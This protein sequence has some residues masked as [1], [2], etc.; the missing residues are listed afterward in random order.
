[1]VPSLLAG[2]LVVG[3]IQVASVS[4]RPARTHYPTKWG[5]NPVRTWGF[6]PGAPQGEFRD[7]VRE[8]VQPWNALGQAHRWNEGG[9][10]AE[11]FDPMTQCPPVANVNGIWFRNI[12]G[13]GNTLAVVAPC[14]FGG[15]NLKYSA[16]MIVDSGQLQPGFHTGAAAPLPTQVDL[17]STVT[18][19]W[20][21]MTGFTGPAATGG[22]F[23]QNDP[24][25]CN[26]AIIHTMCPFIAPGDAQQRTLEVEDRATFVE[27]Y[28]QGYWLVTSEGQVSAF[29]R[30]A[31]QGDRR[32][33]PLN[34]PI[35]GMASRPTALGYWL[36]GQDGGIFTYGDAQFFGST[37]SLAL[38]RPIVGIAPTPS[39]N[40]YWL[41][42]SDG[43]IFTFGDAGFFGST[44]SL[45]LNR[46]VVGM[47]STPSGNG[48][49]L[50]A[51]DGGIFSFGDA[52]FHGSTGAISL[53]QPVIGMS[54]TPFG[55]GYWL[56]AS[57]GGIF[58]FGDAQ[59]LGSAVGATAS[60]VRGMTALAPTVSGLVGA[61]G[62]RIFDQQGRVFGFGDNTAYFGQI[63]NSATVAG[64]SSRG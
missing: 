7:R 43:G 20:G 5:P 34:A 8:G 22:H 53:N 4:A 32:S 16:N 47:A 26:N 23:D 37:G 50:V 64:G 56:V 12:D 9:A 11:T 45:A 59:F 46:P 13:N 27:A 58:N 17:L 39:G 25:L 63:G 28:S 38:N 57:D 18:H 48:Y 52:Q 21:H 44:G 49:W 29:G 31:F 19:E 15:E 62:Y 14:N 33:Q 30:A 61:Q 55:G 42:A 54:R 10:V 1:M 35:I 40:G 41:V 51:S 24:A 3:V 60:P 6:T 36:L 2:I